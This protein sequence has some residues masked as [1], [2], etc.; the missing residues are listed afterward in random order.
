MIPT[1]VQDNFFDRPDELVR[2]ADSLEFS[3]AEEQQYPG[4][5]SAPFSLIDRDLDRFVGQR[6]LRSWFHAGEFSRSTDLNWVADIR[7]QIVEPA[8][9]EQ[10][11]LKNRGWAHYDS[12]I[13]FGGIIYLNPDPEP[14]TGT[15][16][17]IEKDGYA[18]TE[19]EDTK[20]EHKH[21][22]GEEVLDEDY[23]KAYNRVNG[24]YELSISFK[25][26]FNRMIAY[27]SQVSHCART[28]GK[29]QERLTLTFFFK[30]LIGSQPPGARFG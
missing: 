13:K 3:P 22:S 29:D 2:L 25:N 15:D 17:Y 16:I 27:D 23:I 11:H 21:Y 19:D 14:D 10:Y 20:I 7:F 30:D 12:S 1:T 8:H 9:P 4:A 28:F 18:W 26:V 6:L 5:R 24:Q